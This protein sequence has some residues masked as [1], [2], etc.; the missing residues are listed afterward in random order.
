MVCEKGLPRCEVLTNALQAKI[1]FW[2]RIIP[3]R[4]VCSSKS[5]DLVDLVGLVEGGSEE[6][7]ALT[8]FGLPGL[9]PFP[10]PHTVLGQLVGTVEIFVMKAL[11]ALMGKGPEGW[12]STV[13]SETC[14]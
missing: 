6:V 13:R 7:S 9:I 3:Y 11:C 2:R 12:V 8:M 10:Y 1:G 4:R 5:L 14:Q